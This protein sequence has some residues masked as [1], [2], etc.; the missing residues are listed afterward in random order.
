ME[1]VE[2]QGAPRIAAVVP[3]F[4]E[5]SRVG[6]VLARFGP[7][8]TRIY[9]VDDACPESTGRAVEASC[10]DPRVRVLY[11]AEN[12]GVGG[13]TMTGYAQALTDG[14]DV[15]VKVD[16]DGQ[17]DP[18]LIPRLVTPIL[19]GEADYVKGN[20]FHNLDGLAAMPAAR[21]FGN[22][23][24]SFVTKISTGYW[25]VFDPNNGFTAIHAAVL[26]E[27]PLDKISERFFFESDMLFRLNTLQAA[28]L[29]V[30]MRAV[31]RAEESKLRISQ[32]LVDFSV[33]HLRNAVRR[34]FYNYYLRNFNVASLQIVLG[35]VFLA[36]GTIFGAVKW[37]ESLRTGEAATT[38]TVMLAALP[39]LVGVQLLLAF[40]SYDMAS[41]PTRPIHPR[42]TSLD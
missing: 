4:R 25:N 30:P 5:A 31:Y 17:M 32:A 14:A 11:H 35:T 37:C 40:A 42:L 23:V 15:V 16:G 2:Q 10:T 41:V 28:V 22:A 29:D 3:V 1:A 6:A 33:R 27:L 20:R 8:V 7:E 19:R 26:R 21:L 34:I 13:A 12:R 36:F 18:A 39:V 38:G 24:L 9:V